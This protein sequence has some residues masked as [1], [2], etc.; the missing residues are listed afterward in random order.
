METSSAYPPAARERK[1]ELLRHYKDN[2]PGAGVFAVRCVAS[3]QAVYVNAAMNLQ[4]AINRARFQLRLGGHRDKRLQ[5][6]WTQ[7][8]EAAF[9][10]DVVDMLKRHED[11]TEDQQREDLAALLALWREELGV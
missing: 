4:G 1:R 10:I 5:Q 11:T 9:S 8:G 7:Y 6:Q 3:G 2:P